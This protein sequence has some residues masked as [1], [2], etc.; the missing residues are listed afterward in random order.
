LFACGKEIPACDEASASYS[1]HEFEKI[2]AQRIGQ[3]IPDIRIIY[4][5]RNL[6]RRLESAFY[7]HHDSGHKRG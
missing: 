6:Y 7:E 1:L 4:I 5:A 3:Y 2:V